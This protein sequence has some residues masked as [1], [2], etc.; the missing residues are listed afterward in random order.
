MS[1]VYSPKLAT[2]IGPALVAALV[3]TAPAQAYTGKTL[4]SFCSVGTNC[5]DGS[6]SES[7]VI[8]PAGNLFGVTVFGGENNAGVVYEFVPSTGQYSVLHNFCSKTGCADGSEPGRVNLVID[9]QGNLYG[10][11]SEG[12]SAHSAGV[13]FEL[14]RTGSAYREKTLHTFCPKKTC[15]HDGS[16]PRDGLTYA[17]AASGQTYNGTSPL[18]GTTVYG[19]TGGIVFSVAPKA[20]TNKWTRQVLYSFCSQMN[21]GD[22]KDPDTPLYIDSQGNI[23]GTTLEGG[24]SNLGVVFELSPNGS[25]YTETVLY[26]FCAQMNCADG[27]VPDGG[28]VMDA[29]GNLFGTT[30]GGGDSLGQGVV[31]ELSPNGSQ[32]QYSNLENFDGTDGWAPEGALIIDAGGNLFGTTVSGGPKQKGNVFEFNGSI[33]NLYSFCAERGC[34][35]GENPLSGVVEDSAGNLYGTTVKTARRHHNGGTLFELSP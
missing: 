30:E 23:Y 31:F 35:D 8:D 4:Y 12:G 7:V 5:A 20:G 10:T 27:D 26:S 22:G 1:K 32:W 9:T 33:Q 25:G 18:Y 3:S 19:E 21:C 24:S 28:V 11:A 16:T 34:A 14:V 6:L 17:G 2:L 13:V 15:A 29:A